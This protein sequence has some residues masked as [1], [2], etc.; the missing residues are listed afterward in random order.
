M[1]KT[2]FTLLALGLTVFNAN[3]QEN[4]LLQG[5]KLSGYGM[6]QYQASDQD[7]A[8]SNTFGLRLARVALDGRAYDDFYYKVQ[9]QINGNVD[10]TAVQNSSSIR[11]VDLF[12]EWQKYEFLRVKAGQFKRP[13]SF[14]NPMHPITQGFMSYS[15]N[16]SK[17]VG[18]SDRTG[19]QASNG[20]DIGVQLQGDLLKNAA[21]R[22]LLH[23][24]VGVFNGQG[25]NV[26][27][28]DNRKDLIGGVWVMPVEGLRIGAFGWTGSRGN[29]T[30]EEYA[31][32]P[33]LNKNVKVEATENV[34]KNRY[35]FS[36]EYAKDD[37]TLRSEY[38]HS[39]G[40]GKSVIGEDMR[41]CDKADGL[42]ALC[43]APVI[44]NKFHAKARYDV[45][46]A[47]ANW[48]VRKIMY[49]VGVDYML[50]K[51]LQLN[52]EYARVNDH[53]RTFDA[54]AMNMVKNTYNIFD[55]ELDFRF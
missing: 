49:E 4:K 44:K 28:A 38:I 10:N 5:V 2:L 12:A 40:K 26:K 46:R 21:G 7:G 35:A 29:M 31:F 36:A 34:T 52:L 6:L 23:Y 18:F 9:M 50:S 19:E 43:I 54:K 15:Q 25:I 33:K 14:E 32:D 1:K 51:H 48:H 3:A 42:Y 16:V 45:Y 22:N 11:L 55:L 47:E 17:L 20:R 41:A 27:D 13:F 30:Y 37:W 8:R 24:Q 39:Q 53:Q